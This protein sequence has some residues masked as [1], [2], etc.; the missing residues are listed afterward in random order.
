[1]FDNVCRVASYPEGGIYEIV[2]GIT[3]L[4]ESYNVKIQYNEPV[5]KIEVELPSCSIPDNGEV[6]PRGTQLARHL[7]A[8]GHVTTLGMNRH[9]SIFGYQEADQC[10]VISQY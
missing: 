10:V 8:H 4:C 9:T 7:A 2:K 3:K 5:T 6:V 1:M